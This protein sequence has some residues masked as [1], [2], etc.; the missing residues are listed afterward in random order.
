M[1]TTRK[2]A[3]DSQIVRETTRGHPI[4]MPS[5]EDSGSRI[6]VILGKLRFDAHDVGARF[7]MKKL[8]DA[9]MEVVFVRFA[10]PQE[11]VEAALQEDAHV[12]GLSALTGAHLMVCEDLMAA[13]EQAGL[14]DRLVVVGGVIADE[15]ADKLRALGVDGV[16]GSGSKPAAVVEFIREHVDP[17]A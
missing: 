6:R 16:F 3:D 1:S 13:L 17:N 7:V 11:L 5:P 9:G 15:D 12:I 2:R 10:L 14:D 8:V 4:N